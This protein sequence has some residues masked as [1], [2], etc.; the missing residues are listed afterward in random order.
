MI[1]SA[2]KNTNFRQVCK[3]KFSWIAE[4][5]NDGVC[6]IGSLHLTDLAYILC[7]Q[8]AWAWGMQCVWQGAPV[9]GMADVLI[10]AF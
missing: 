8:E 7:R 4:N 10:S 9:W 6:S 1:D 2:S 3:R 5:D